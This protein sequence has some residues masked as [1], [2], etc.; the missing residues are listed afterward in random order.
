[1]TT[2]G[3]AF[4]P[5]GQ[6]VAV[7]GWGESSVWNVD[8]GARAFTLDT[9]GSRTVEEVAWSPDGRHLVTAGDDGVLVFWNAATGRVAG[10]LFVLAGQDEWLFV[11]PD[12]RMDGSRRALD[13]LVAWRTATGIAV[14]A[15]ATRRARVDGLWRAVAGAP[16]GA[17]PR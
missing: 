4:S 11:T 9:G 5:T 12:G 15:R 7:A 16:S 6:Q 1:V 8:S 14:D 2:R 10:S 13:T 3:L 17:P